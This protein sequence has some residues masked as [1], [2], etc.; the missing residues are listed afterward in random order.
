M[1]RRASRDNFVDI[2]F[3]SRNCL[4]QDYM[5]SHLPAHGCTRGGLEPF[6][7][8]FLGFRIQLQRF[9]RSQQAT[10]EMKHLHG[11]TMIL[12]IIKVEAYR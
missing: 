7:I 10:L 1:G 9:L 5:Y 3:V 12:L 6:E 4:T 11:R 8:R 2:G